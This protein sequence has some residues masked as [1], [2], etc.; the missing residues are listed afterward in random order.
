VEWLSRHYDDHDAFPEQ[1][2]GIVVVIVPGEPFHFETDAP[3]ASEEQSPWLR[4]EEYLMGTEDKVTAPAGDERDDLETINDIG[5]K[6]ADALHQ[7]GVLYYEDLARYTPQDLSQTLLEQ[8]GVKV[9]PDRIEAKEWI[10]QA[11][12]LAQ[13]ANPGR[14]PVSEETE[15]TENPRHTSTKSRW[16]Q[17]AGFYVIFDYELDEQGERMWQTRVFHEESRVEEPFPGIDP[18]VWVKWILEHAKLPV[19]VE[20]VPAQTADAET[21]PAPIEVGEPAPAQTEVAEPPPTTTLEG[22]RTDSQPR[23]EPV[24]TV[25]FQYLGSTGV[26]VI[27][28][29]THRRYHFDHPGSVLAVDPKDRYALATVSVLRQVGKPTEAVR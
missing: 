4:S 3:A 16:K 7:I 6:Y 2:E 12:E 28:R 21:A 20:P 13:Q 17:H 29:K 11:R 22:V 23:P 25:Y 24:P 14:T 1:V 19:A 26:T 15:D 10:E 27:A 5:P 18:A 9:S 8:T